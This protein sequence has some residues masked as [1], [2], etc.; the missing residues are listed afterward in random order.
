MSSRNKTYSRDK[1]TLQLFIVMILALSL[2]LAM[3]VSSEAATRANAGPNIDP[4][5]S[6]GPPPPQVVEVGLCN[7]GTCYGGQDDGQACLDDSDC[8]G[9]IVP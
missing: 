5:D 4:P 7:F 3:P 1:S 2:C 6:A 8:A 9:E